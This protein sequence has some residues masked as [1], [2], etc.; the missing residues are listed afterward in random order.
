MANWLCAPASEDYHPDVISPLPSLDVATRALLAEVQSNIDGKLTV[1]RNFQPTMLDVSIREPTA[2]SSWA[3]R[4]S[5]KH[6]ILRLVRGFGFRDIVLA[7]FKAAYAVDDEF[8]EALSDEQKR[9]GFAFSDLGELDR[10]GKLV[11]DADH[12]VPLGKAAR[13]VPNVLFE[14][15]VKDHDAE[16]AALL[17][18][19]L[20]QSITYIREQW[21]NRGIERGAEQGRVYVNIYDTLEAFYTNTEIYA[22]IIRQ[23]GGHPGVDAVLFEDEIGSSF[24]FQIGELTRLIRSVTPPPKKLLVHIHESSGTAYA[25]ALEVVLAGADGLWAGFTPCGGHVGHAA[26]SVFLANLLRVKN[27]HVCEQFAMHTTVP[28]ARALDARN[29]PIPTDPLHP[30]IGAGAYL[31]SLFD[32]EQRPERPMALAPEAVGATRGFRVVP[33]IANEYA[34]ARRLDELGITYEPDPTPLPS[35]PGG[36]GGVKLERSVFDAMW[37]LMQQSLIAGRKVDCS[38]EATLREYLD[39]ARQIAKAAKP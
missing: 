14:F 36:P 3:H 39:R 18:D 6:D 33:A 25:S 20:D 17:L 2:Y 8:C 38:D 35:P 16:A 1:L 31:S 27:P 28:L 12:S 22:R 26:S 4:L 32:F 15:G 13:L 9:G 7:A 21:S 5:D 37:E 34:L 30:V 10:A 23:I 29:E 19:Q 11:V 24:H